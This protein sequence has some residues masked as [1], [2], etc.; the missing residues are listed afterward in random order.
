MHKAFAV[1]NTGP[2]AQNNCEYV[3]R[4]VSPRLKTALARDH[5]NEQSKQHIFD[6]RLCSV[7]GDS[8]VQRG[9]LVSLGNSP[10]RLSYS[11]QEDS[12]VNGQSGLS[13]LP[14]LLVVSRNVSR[15]IRT[16]KPWTLLTPKM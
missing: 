4:W 13:I 3:K 16:A 2:N 12:M 7:H 1:R 6:M 14:P 8:A 9:Y 5:L 11:A 15:V 10:V